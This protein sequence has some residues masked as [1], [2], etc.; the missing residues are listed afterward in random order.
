MTEYLLEKA[1]ARINPIDEIECVAYGYAALRFLLLCKT[2][3]DMDSSKMVGNRLLSKGIVQVLTI[4]L[5]IFNDIVRTNK[6]ILVF[7]LLLSF[8]FKACSK[9]LSDQHIHALFQLSETLREAFNFITVSKH[10]IKLDESVNL[11]GP[12]LLIL[13]QCCTDDIEIQ[14]QILRTLSVISEIE[15]CNRLLSDKV[16]ELGTFLKPLPEK[17]RETKK[18]FVFMCRLGYIIGN[19]IEQHDNA[20][21]LFYD[22]KEVMSYLLNSLEFHAN[23]NVK[24]ISSSKMSKNDVLIKLIRI[25]ANLSVNSYVGSNLGDSSLGV[26]LLQML[27]QVK[28]LKVHTINIIFPPTYLLTFTTDN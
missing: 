13:L 20:R 22:N 26:I 24:N 28:E 15:F 6:T 3:N 16:I 4:H 14:L 11:V 10:L 18:G 23:G 2:Y 9:R 8:L 7:C 27:L 5:Q 12:Q 19:I 17:F 25:V 1:V 21:I